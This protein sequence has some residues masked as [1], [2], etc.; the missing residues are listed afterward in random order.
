MNLADIF[1]NR[2]LDLITQ[3]NVNCRNL[4]S[5]LYCRILVGNTFGTTP[6]YEAFFSDQFEVVKEMLENATE[7]GNN[8]GL[9]EF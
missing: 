8:K 6:L 5:L 1:N 2:W 9:Q 7:Y 4:N 3:N